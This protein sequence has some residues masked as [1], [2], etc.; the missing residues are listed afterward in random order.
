MMR[1]GGPV[2]DNYWVGGGKDIFVSDSKVVVG[3][4]ASSNDLA[5]VAAIWVDGQLIYLED[6]QEFSSVVNSI[7]VQ[8]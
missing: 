2:Y 4:W 1:L 6:E 5:Q 3:G 8:Q 7:F